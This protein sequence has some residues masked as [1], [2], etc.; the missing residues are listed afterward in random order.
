MVRYFGQTF[1]YLKKNFLLPIICFVVPSV[2]A[3]FLSTPYWEVAFV[4]G[5]DETPYIS[6]AQTFRLM[7]GDSWQYLW[8]VIVVSIV[9]IF[10]AALMMSAM[11]RH[12][13]TGRLS[14]RGAWTLINNSVFAIAIGVAVMC[15][16]SIIW[17]FIVFGIV[18]LVQVSSEA[19][20]MSPNATIA[21]IAA[22]AVLAFILHVLINTPILFWAPI[23]FIYGYRFRDAA[24]ASF[25]LTG[26]RLFTS[27]LLPM[28]ICAGIQLLIGFLDVHRAV[29]I[30]MNF[31]VF[32]FTNSFVTCFTMLSFYGI[33]ELDRRDIKPYHAPIPRVKEQT[34]KAKQDVMPVDDS[35]ADG[36]NGGD[37]EIKTQGKQTSRS[38]E[39]RQNANSRDGKAKRNGHVKKN[40]KAKEKTGEPQ[41]GNADAKERGDVV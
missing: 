20:N 3:C 40:V 19:M 37:K 16:V 28:I 38:T 22:I 41:T 17:R 31:F 10:G 15:A 13:R 26:N 4:T 14:L 32:L 6:A 7:F 8:P 24:A 34:E 39:N 18:M 23:M 33:S 30:V 25:K 12:F 2:V 29:A 11:D 21:V 27:L 36:A 9:Q 5:F 1:S 35:T